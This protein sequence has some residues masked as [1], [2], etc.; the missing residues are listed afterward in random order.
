[1]ALTTIA[2]YYPS[3]SLDFLD[4]EVYTV[5][6]KEQILPLKINAVSNK[7][8]HISPTGRFI[9]LF[10]ETFQISMTKY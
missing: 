2:Y 1:M 6:N 3:I 9:L 8:E 7:K 5:C 4:F 10:P